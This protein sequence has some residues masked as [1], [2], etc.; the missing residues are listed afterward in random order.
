MKALLVSSYF[1]PYVS[2]VT[3]YCRTLANSLVSEGCEVEVLTGRHRSDLPSV[4]SM[5]GVTVRREPI[6]FRLSKGYISLPFIRSFL[7]CHTN[8]DVVNLHAPMLEAGLFASLSKRPVVLT[9]QCDMASVGSPLERVAVAAVQ[10][11]ARVAA[12]QSANVA[13][14]SSDYAA[15][16]R[17]L[18]NIDVTQIRPPNRFHKRATLQQSQTSEPDVFQRQADVVRLGFVGRFVT[19]KGIEVLLDSIRLITQGKVVLHLAGDF[20]EVAGGSNFDQL[21]SKLLALGSQ[22]SVLGKLSDDQLIDHYNTIDILVLPSVNRFEAFGMVQL[23]AMSF[24]AIP[25]ASNMPG[26]RDLVLE[27]RAGELA[28][29]GSARSLAAAIDRAIERRRRVSRAETAKTALEAFPQTLGQQYLAAF[30]SVRASRLENV[31]APPR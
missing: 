16:S 6:N 14:L 30:E 10:Q 26:V 29:P 1:L 4:E 19:E 25:V 15:S 3:E 8:F 31:R 24:G 20:G 11:S 17:I 5:D 28:D 23:E 7:E 22:V 12:A 9:Y 27:T 13:V 18:R 2:G 21:R